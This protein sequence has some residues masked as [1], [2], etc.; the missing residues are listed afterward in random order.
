MDLREFLPTDDLD[1]FDERIVDS[2]CHVE[3]LEQIVVLLLFCVE[4]V[5]YRLVKALFFDMH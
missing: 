5:D 2:F 1:V 4:V 3:L